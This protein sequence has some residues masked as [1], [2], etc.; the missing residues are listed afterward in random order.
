MRAG[1]EVA[2]EGVCKTILWS[3]AFT[4]NPTQQRNARQRTAPRKST[5]MYAKYMAD[6]N[7]TCVSIAAVARI[8]Y[9]RARQTVVT[10]VYRVC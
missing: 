10:E 6:Y 8:S 9:L 5:L 4:Q 2:S 1:F 3:R 7:N